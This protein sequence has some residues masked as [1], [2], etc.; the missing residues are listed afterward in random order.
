[1]AMPGF[2]PP[3]GAP[4]GPNTATP[5]KAEIDPGACFLSRY[6]EGTRRVVAL[7]PDQLPTFSPQECQ[8]LSQGESALIPL[9]CS[10]SHAVNS[11]GLRVDDL[12]T[13]MHD[14][15]SQVANC[16]IR[17]EIRDLRNSIS[18]LSRRVTP[19][20]VRHTPSNPTSSRPN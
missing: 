7:S 9:L 2:P 14:L 15:G 10:T 5:S 4:S 12:H 1:M 11:I 16:L 13:K 20:V 6:L 17:P 19:P 3:F 18:D 8:T